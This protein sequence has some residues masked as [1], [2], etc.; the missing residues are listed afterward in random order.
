M[1]SMQACLEELG[2]KE[3]LLSD[4]Q[5]QFLDENGYLILPTALDRA[6]VDSARGSRFD[7]LV[8]LEGD[9]AGI[10]VSQEAGS[11]R[12]ANLVDK[13]PLF[14]RCWTYPAQLAAVVHVFAGRNFKLHSVNGRSAHPRPWVAG[15]PPGLARGR[16]SGR[17]PRL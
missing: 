15:A 7:E 16:P 11:D 5:F 4:E 9:K 14:D 8:A 10:E 17:L 2:V 12:L 13:D 6:T 1:S 3:S